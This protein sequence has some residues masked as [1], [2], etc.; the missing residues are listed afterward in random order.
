MAERQR[1]TL[2]FE[3]FDGDMSLHDVGRA[4]GKRN[5]VC[6]SVHGLDGEEFVPLGW[7]EIGQLCRAG[8]PR[9]PHNRGVRA[10]LRDETRRLLPA[11]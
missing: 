3:V 4:R 11:S 9:I 1:R 8:L 2:G 10:G 5:G 6:R 7:I